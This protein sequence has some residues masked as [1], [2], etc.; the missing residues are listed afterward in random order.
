[1]SSTKH[2]STGITLAF[3]ITMIMRDT[4]RQSRPANGFEPGSKP[5]YPPLRPAGYAMG[6]PRLFPPEQAF[7]R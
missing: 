3:I 7:P 6:L 5:A 4:H 2:A 1:M